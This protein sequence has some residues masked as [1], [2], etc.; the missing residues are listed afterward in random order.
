MKRLFL[1][2][3]VLALVSL[4]V[5]SAHAGHLWLQDGQPSVQLFAGQGVNITIDNRNTLPRLAHNLS[6]QEPQ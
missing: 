1:C 5:G 6:R 3:A 2:S 4:T